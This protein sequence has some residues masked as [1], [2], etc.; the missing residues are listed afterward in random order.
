LIK[1][2]GEDKYEL[3]SYLSD[4]VNFSKFKALEL[5]KKTVVVDFAD[6]ARKIP[7]LF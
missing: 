4:T 1:E 5:V 6:W 7:Y 3:N 2:F